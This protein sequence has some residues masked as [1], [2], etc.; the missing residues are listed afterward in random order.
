M[1]L[2]F[3]LI[4]GKQVRL[5]LGK[6][7]TKKDLRKMNETLTRHGRT[8]NELEQMI[9]NDEEDSRTNSNSNN[10][11]SYNLSDA[12]N[13]MSEQQQG[14]GDAAGG[15]GGDGGGSKRRSSTL[16]AMELNNV[17]STPIPFAVEDGVLSETFSQR[18]DVERQFGPG[19]ILSVEPCPMSISN[20]ATL[21]KV[22]LLFRSLRL[23]TLYL[24]NE[25]NKFIGTV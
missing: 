4:F 8:T 22:D 10:G 21:H 7:T 23:T 2:F 6:E 24:H 9:G 14:D 11:S 3:F 16:G 15:G 13:S 20:T 1:S 19:K 18:S 5:Y 25:V 12:L 17:L